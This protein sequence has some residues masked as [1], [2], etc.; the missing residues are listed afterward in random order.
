MQTLTGRTCVFAGATAGDGRDAVKALC[1]G[2]M[3]VVLMTHQP[4]KAQSLIDEVKAAGCT[5]D[6]IAYARADGGPA[7][8]NPETYKELEKKY[9]SVDVVICNTGGNG[10]VGGIDDVT[11][12]ELM[13]G[14]EHLTLTSYLMMRTALPYL[15]RS[16]APRVIFM[17][18]VEGCQGGTLEGLANAVGK[19]A[20]RSLTLN[21]AA[22]LAHEGITVNCIAKGAIPRIGDQPEDAP[23]PETMLPHIPMGKLGTPE[24]LAQAICF[25]ASEESGYITG[26]T[27]ELSGGMNLGR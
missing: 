6:C 17:T 20:V 21:A 14:V 23:R 22:R 7:E 24:D 27:L 25:L 19:G 10:K 9:G 3:N 4:E 12:E 1:A 13:K 18:T 11:G 8:Q 16:K 15:R 26:Q 2:G 5:G